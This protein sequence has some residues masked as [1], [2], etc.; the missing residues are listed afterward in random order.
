MAEVANNLSATINQ[1]PDAVHVRVGPL[2]Q[3]NDGNLH[4][5][6][7]PSDALALELASMG[8]LFLFAR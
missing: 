4:W 7:K 3:M 2:E 5:A 8:H 1:Q 6:K